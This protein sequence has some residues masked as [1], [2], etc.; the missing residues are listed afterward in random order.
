M[1][2][3]SPST[4]QPWV[5]QLLEG[6]PWPRP[7]RRRRSAGPTG[8]SRGTGPGP[9]GRRRRARSPGPSSWRRS[10]RSRSRTSRPG[11]RSSLVKPIGLA[12]VGAGEA[13]GQDLGGVLGKPGVGAFGAEQVADERAM[14]SSVHD[15]LAAVVAVE[16]GDGQAP[17]ALAG[18]APVGALADHGLHAVHAPGG[19]PADIVAGRARRRP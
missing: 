14:V 16:H 1:A 6:A 15:G 4:V 5:M 8:T 18:D 19:H 12:A 17:A 11:C 13:L 9:P 10:G 3:P 2:L 7:W